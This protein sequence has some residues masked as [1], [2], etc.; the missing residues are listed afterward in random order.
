MKCP[1]CGSNKTESLWNVGTDS[2]VCIAC[3]TIFTAWQQAEID[4][5]RGLLE[6]SKLRILPQRTPFIPDDR[7]GPGIPEARK[8]MEQESHILT[9][10]DL[11]GR[12]LKLTLEIDQKQSRIEELEG[13]LE[14]IRIKVQNAESKLWHDPALRMREISAIASKG[15]PRKGDGDE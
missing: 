14:E 9:H 1:K 3:D 5:L 13:L 6:E 2:S 8:E 7:I 4:R 11:V 12:V 10:D 15:V